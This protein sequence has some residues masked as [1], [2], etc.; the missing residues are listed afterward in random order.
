MGHKLKLL[1][2][3][4]LCSSLM[5][6]CINTIFRGVLPLKGC[7]FYVKNLDSKIK[8]SIFW[9]IYESAEIRFIKKYID[10]QYD[11]VDL[12]SSIGVSSVFIGKEKVT[13][14]VS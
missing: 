7:R 1:I 11:I 8:A 4:I 5:G 13:A 9:G 3:K 14:Q 2:A 10:D 12:G 6:V